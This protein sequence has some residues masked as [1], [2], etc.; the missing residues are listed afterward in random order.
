[1]QECSAKT[2][3][4]IIG[5]RFSGGLKRDCVCVHL[6]HALYKHEHHNLAGCVL[7]CAAK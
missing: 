5:L 1:M 3:I 4:L 7:I 2:R 6:S